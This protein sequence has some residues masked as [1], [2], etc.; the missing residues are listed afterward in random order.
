MAGLFMLQLQSLDHQ[1]VRRG[2]RPTNFNHIIAS[3]LFPE[4][5]RKSY[6]SNFK[7]HFGIFCNLLR[8]KNQK[9]NL[10]QDLA[11]CLIY[12]PRKMEASRYSICP[13]ICLPALQHLL[14]CNVQLFGIMVIMKVLHDLFQ[15][16]SKDRTKG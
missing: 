15:L 11:I 10:V 1:K 6:S 9:V 7:V 8:R 14:S 16:P 2:Q 3:F 13:S 5:R 4:K 12:K